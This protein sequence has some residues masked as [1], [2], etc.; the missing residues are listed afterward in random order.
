MT[1]QPGVLLARTGFFENGSNLCQDLQLC[2]ACMGDSS[3]T[4][5]SHK[6]MS[7]YNMTY[8]APILTVMSASG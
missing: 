2:L 3:V 8:R 5:I 4:N 6:V 7:I 1:G